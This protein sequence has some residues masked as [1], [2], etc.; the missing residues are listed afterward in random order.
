MLPLSCAGVRLQGLGMRRK[1]L[2]K[3]FVHFFQ[4]RHAGMI[5]LM[6]QDQQPHGFWQPAL[7]RA[8]HVMEA[9]RVIYHFFMGASVSR[10][11]FGAP[12]GQ[13]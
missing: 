3:A 13:V 2:S 8:Q 1:S 12:I 7:M 9:G 5:A 4:V 10:P 11:G 6:C